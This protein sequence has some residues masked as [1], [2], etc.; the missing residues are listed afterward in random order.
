M[1]RFNFR[2]I[3]C[4]C[5][6]LSVIYGQTVEIKYLDDVS[7]PGISFYLIIGFCVL[8]ILLEQRLHSPKRFLQSFSVMMVYLLL[9]A[10]ATQ[11]SLRVFFKNYVFMV[12]IFFAYCYMLIGNNDFHIVL[13]AFVEVILFI[14]C[15]TVFFWLFGSVLGIIR[16]RAMTYTWAGNTYRTYNYYYL[17]FENPIQNQ[18]L[19]GMTIPRNCGI[20]TEAPAYSGFLLYAVGIELFARKTVNK[21]RLIILLITILTVQ[22]TKAYVVLIFLFGVMYLTKEVKNRSRGYMILRLAAGLLVIA[23]AAFALWHIL[24]DK[25]ETYSFI[26]RVNH[27]NAGLRTWLD[28]PLFGAGYTNREAYVGNQEEGVGYGHAS[29]G[30]TIL[31]AYGGVYLLAFYL[32]AYFYALRNPAVQ[33]NKKKFNFFAL[34]LLMNLFISNSAFG[35]PYKF[36][37][38]A[39]YAAGVQPNAVSLI[40]MRTQRKQKQ[41]KRIVRETGARERVGESW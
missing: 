14:C 40:S 10:L 29:M 33:E 32:G 1:L 16:G 7:F 30:L 12:L 11:Y 41:K 6:V 37:I 18:N 15:I 38:A 35:G 31:L 28:N 27:F 4:L 13:D 26:A 3:N 24:E 23:G 19:L 5:L 34:M 25:S 39:G 17:Y 8:G 21:R 20:F 36:M 2:K 9:Y 22:S